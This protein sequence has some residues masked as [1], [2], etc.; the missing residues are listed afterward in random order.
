MMKKLT[1]IILCMILV[2]GLALT[3]NAAEY[4]PVFDKA[5]ILSDFDA[6]F[7]AERAQEISQLAEIDIVILTVPSLDGKTA[8]AYADDYFDYNYGSDGILLL[9]DM[10]SRQWHISTCGAAIEA[11]ADTDLMDMEDGLMRYL[12]DGRF[13]DAFHQFLSDAEYYVSDEGV[14]DLEA[15]LFIAVPA[16]AVIALIV[17]LIMRFAMNTKRPQRSAESYLISGSE[18]LRRQQ[19]LFLYSNVIKTARPQNNSSGGSSTHRSSSG[20]SHGGRGGR[21]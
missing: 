19:D 18:N 13:A 2:L 11:F 15:S 4:P 1:S 12:P 16:S 6:E 3:A 10:G 20:R 14:S 21:F 5:G 17:I 7:L 8:M 9:I